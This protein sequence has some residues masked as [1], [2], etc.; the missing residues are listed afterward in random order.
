M[1]EILMLL[2]APWNFDREQSHLVTPVHR[3]LRSGPAIALIVARSSPFRESLAVLMRAIPQIGHIEQAEDLVSALE[4]EFDGQPDLM[5]CDFES[6]RDGTA[7]RLHRLKAR[8][9][10]MRCVVL[11]E[12]KAARHHA[13]TM[14]ADVVL[15]KGILAA[16]LLETVEEWLSRGQGDKD[17]DATS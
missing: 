13:Q 12:N 6:V 11:V 4:L 2:R 15:T 1:V 7:D 17:S 9:R 16:R 8:W 14:G 3:T 5:L 10:S